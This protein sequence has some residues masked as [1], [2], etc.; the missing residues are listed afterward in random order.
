MI[1]KTLMD[2]KLSVKGLKKVKIFKHTILTSVILF[3]LIGN[4][5]KPAKA[6]VEKSYLIAQ[7]QLSTNQNITK[8]QNTERFFNVI[9]LSI[10]L[11]FAWLLPNIFTLIQ[12]N[13]F[14]SKSGLD[15]LLMSKE[16]PKT[17]LSSSKTQLPIDEND[18][19][20]YLK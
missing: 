20:L 9:L 13:I 14:L 2:S 4:P 7:E 18:E 15:K 11:L 10:T 3:C 1:V 16:S 5:S 17:K 12:F 8:S 19:S 6:N